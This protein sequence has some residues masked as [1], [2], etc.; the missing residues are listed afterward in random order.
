MFASVW[1]PI[2]KL[3][4]NL[5]KVSSNESKQKPQMGEENNWPLISVSY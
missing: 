1:K 2:W 4:W 5:E 3:I